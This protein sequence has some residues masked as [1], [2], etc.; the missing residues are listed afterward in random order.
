MAIA[1]L[2]RTLELGTLR[3]ANPPK[4]RSTPRD[5][6]NGFDEGL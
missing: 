3:P 5:F 1:E 2:K 4:K 6:D